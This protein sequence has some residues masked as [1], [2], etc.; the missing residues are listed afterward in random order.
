MRSLNG[1]PSAS[2]PVTVIGTACVILGGGREKKEDAVDPAVGI[3]FHK[4]VGDHVSE[5][6]TLATIHYNAE[7]RFLR[8]RQLLEASCVIADAPPAQSRPLIHRV[9]GS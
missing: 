9:I 4:K 3:V 5:G 2:T 6:E 7:T 8:A 1:C